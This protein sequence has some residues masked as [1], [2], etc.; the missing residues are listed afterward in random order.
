[1][2]YDCYLEAS[3]YEGTDKLRE[4]YLKK[5]GYPARRRVVTIYCAAIIDKQSSKQGQG[6]CCLT[7]ELPTPSSV[8]L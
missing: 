4:T 7:V 6:P 1:M 5:G 2:Y 3:L 8:F